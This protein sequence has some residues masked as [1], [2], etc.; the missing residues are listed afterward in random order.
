MSKLTDAEI[1]KA[2]ECCKTLNCVKC[3]RIEDFKNTSACLEKMIA[4]AIDLIKRQ[5]AEIEKFAKYLSCYER[6]T[7]DG[8]L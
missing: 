3:G 5:Q 6:R 4:D 7:D 8:N 2:L 1:L